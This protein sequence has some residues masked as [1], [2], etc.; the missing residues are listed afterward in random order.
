MSTVFY[1]YDYK[2]HPRTNMIKKVK[3]RNGEYDYNPITGAAILIS[4][5]AYAKKRKH[6]TRFTLANPH[7][8]LLSKSL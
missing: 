6:L 2:D 4:I 7:L 8:K 5:E 3:I 1:T